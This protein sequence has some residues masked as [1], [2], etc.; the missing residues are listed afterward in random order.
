VLVEDRLFATLDPTVRR[1]VLPGGRVALFADTVGFIRKLPH[2]LV[3][4]F[5][6][7]L[8]EAAGADLLLHLV[9]L[10]DPAWEE[11]ASVGEQ[12]LAELGLQDLPRSR[13]YTKADAVPEGVLKRIR[14][15]D[16]SA[17]AI[18]ARTGQGMERLTEMLVSRLRE[19]EQ[20]IKLTVDADRKDL[21]SRVY[22]LLSVAAESRR[23]GVVDLSVE[24]PRPVVER[25]RRE[26][27]REGALR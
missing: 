8:E 10:A 25:I 22:R 3:A 23:D 4:S 14:R 13:V 15:V 24:G 11:Q 1:G 6:S 21:V 18:S 27:E 12:A 16:P 5:R 20:R 19:G 26:I 7:T 9:D 17:V 2:N